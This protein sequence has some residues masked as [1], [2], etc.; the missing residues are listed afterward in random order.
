MAEGKPIILDD[1][2]ETTFIRGYITCVKCKQKMYLKQC[3]KN[4]S[5]M[6]M[7]I[8][9]KDEWI[10]ELLTEVDELEEWNESG[11]NLL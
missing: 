6:Q 4:R 2:K 1:A 11:G 9:A 10:N 3:D 8:K 7:I 5:E